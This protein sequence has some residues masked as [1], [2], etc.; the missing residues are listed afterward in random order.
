MLLLLSF[1][2]KWITVSFRQEYQL[3]SFF[4]IKGTI[5]DKYLNKFMTFFDSFN[6]LNFFLPAVY[7]Q[8]KYFSLGVQTQPLFGF[9]SHLHFFLTSLLTISYVFIVF[10]IFILIKIQAKHFPLHLYY[11][12]LPLYQ[13]N[14]DLN[15]LC[16][17]NPQS[18][19]LKR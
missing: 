11:L 8:N 14:F 15:F 18:K 5:V 1:F 9:C 6:I 13:A 19:Y 7:P 2:I 12:C 10:P 17:L 4:N 3:I 16:F